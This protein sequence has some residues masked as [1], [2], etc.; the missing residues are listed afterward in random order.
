MVLSVVAKGMPQGVNHP[1][2][3]ALGWMVSLAGE[4]W[5]LLPL[6]RSDPIGVGAAVGAALS[7][8]RPRKDWRLMTASACSQVI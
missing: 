8:Y 7:C 2:E 3:D 6:P 4:V 1:P 5:H